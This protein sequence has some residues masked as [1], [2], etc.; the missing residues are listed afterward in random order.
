MYLRHAFQYLTVSIV[1]LG[2]CWLWIRH[3]LDTTDTGYAIVNAYLAF[4]DPVAVSY[5]AILATSN[6]IA[7]LPTYVI[8]TNVLL[9]RLI[10]SVWFVMLA[11]G[12]VSYT[13]RRAERHYAQYHWL[14][15]TAT[16]NAV[17][18]G[19]VALLTV[20]F[21]S[22]RVS[23]YWINNYDSI[24]ALLAVLIALV[25]AK[26]ATASIQATAKWAVLSG[27][28][29]VAFI[30]ARAPAG[31]AIGIVPLIG[32]IL[33]PYKLRYTGYGVLGLVLGAGVFA[34]ILVASGQEALWW[35]SIVDIIA[36]AQRSDIDHGASTMLPAFMKSASLIVL[37]A[38]GTLLPLRIWADNHKLRAYCIAVVCVGLAVAGFLQP[39]RYIRLVAGVVIGLL[40]DQY[41]Q[42]TRIPIPSKVYRGTKALIVLSI[43]CIFVVPFGSSSLLNKLGYGI[44][45]AMPLA[46][47]VALLSMRL[48][49]PRSLAL[50][51]LLL[52]IGVP[53]ALLRYQA[54]HQD[55][56]RNALVAHTENTEVHAIATS[57][58]RAT[59]L[60]EAAKAIEQY[61][62]TKDKI[63]ITGG[64]PIL[65]AM[66]HRWP[67]LTT[68][69]PYLMHAPMLEQAIEQRIRTVGK[70]R[71]ILRALHETSTADWP[72]D[73]SQI[74][75]PRTNKNERVLSKLLRRGYL[76]AWRNPYF[77]LYR[78]TP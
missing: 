18:V 66:T 8:G 32:L 24:A 4:R 64:V 22:H 63:L 15:T 74:T 70:P 59:A 7:S 5:A 36:Y 42:F 3:G 78:R 75:H 37:V 57:P 44:W 72:A 47:W 56:P 19:I 33:S 76:M 39:D 69:W 23:F 54:V 10:F 53:S 40:V 46:L 28:L 16:A 52:G 62:P 25:T 65:H 6:W 43:C 45:L 58:A 48:H 67:Y 2:Y 29:C 51:L 68:P 49:L 61:I 41:W 77:I 17:Q 11:T 26:A 50:L 34:A 12:L 1:C 20:A 9:H 73:P 21:S 35:Q 27:T 71:W 14:P 31:L 60:A 13:Y 38:F 55:I 30:T